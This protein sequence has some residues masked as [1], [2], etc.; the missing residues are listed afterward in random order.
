[1][2]ASTVFAGTVS[3]SGLLEMTRGFRSSLAFSM[4]ATAVSPDRLAASTAQNPSGLDGFDWSTRVDERMDRVGRRVAD[5]G[6]LR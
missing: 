2:A 4:S 3:R 6:R 1:M 5:D